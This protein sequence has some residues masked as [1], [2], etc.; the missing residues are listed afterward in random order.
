MQPD[1]DLTEWWTLLAITV[2]TSLGFGP[3]VGSKLQGRRAVARCFPQAA[4]QDHVTA[5][6]AGE[7]VPTRSIPA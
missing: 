5:A 4:H 6:M 1:D 7:Q 2:A 3:D